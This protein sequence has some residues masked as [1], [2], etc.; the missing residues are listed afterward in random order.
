[1]LWALTPVV[2]S[3]CGAQPAQAQAAWRFRWQT[4]QVLTYRV[5]Q[6]TRSLEVDADGKVETKTKIRL[7]KRWQVLAVD[8]DGVATLSHSLVSLRLEN[9]APSGEVLLF[10]SADPAKSDPQLREQMTP[11][12]GVPLSTLRVDGLGRLLEVKESKF[13][14]ASRYEAELPFL[15]VLPGAEAQPGQ[16]WQRTYQITCEPPQGTGEKYAAMQTYTCKRVE[17][18]GVYL[19]LKTAMKTLPEA[20][21]DQ[22]PLLRFQPEGEVVFDRRNGRLHAARLQ[23][24]KELKGH[25]GAGSSYLFESTY[26]EQYAGDK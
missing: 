16:S 8:K 19:E 4:G 14:P 6:Q 15:I 17:G 7:V 2:V 23:V 26:T 21:G 5:E 9:T 20:L 11:L 24:H 1:M 3:L 10:D 18:V 12:L 13:G 25:Q 22:V